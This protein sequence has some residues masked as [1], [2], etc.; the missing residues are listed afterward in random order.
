MSLNDSIVEGL[1]DSSRFSTAFAEP[2]AGPWQRLRMLLHTWFVDH[3]LLRMLYANRHRVAP[4]VFRSNHPLP[5]QVASAA[6]LG[7]KTIICLRRKRSVPAAFGLEEEACR[8]HDIRLIELPLC[9]RA[10]PKPEDIERLRRLFNSVRFPILMHCKS[11]ADRAGLAAAL[12]LLLQLETEPSEAARQLALRY[13]HVRQAKTGILDRF[14]EDYAEH[15][16]AHGT[17]FIDW[18]R[19]HYD[20]ADLTRRFRAQW[21]ACQLNTWILRRE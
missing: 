10:A 5:H 20:P 9:S 3:G 7:V 12:Y 4:G 21:W 13:G 15:R 17:S 14:I 19:N 11:G 1:F 8:R 6:S 2:Q 18:V 16:A